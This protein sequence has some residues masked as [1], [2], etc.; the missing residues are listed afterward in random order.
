M[1]MMMM[2]MM[3]IFKRGQLTTM[4]IL[5]KNLTFGFKLVRFHGRCVEV[6]LNLQTIAFIESNLKIEDI[7]HSLNNS[8]HYQ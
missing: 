7:F 6:L 8:M 2:M 3:M 5:K 1:M 4:K